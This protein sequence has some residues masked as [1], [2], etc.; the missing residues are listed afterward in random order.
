MD[1]VT[2]FAMPK[3]CEPKPSI[4]GSTLTRLGQ[5]SNHVKIPVGYLG[6]S[7]TAM[8]LIGGPAYSTPAGLD[9]D[10]NIARSPIQLSDA[11]RSI[12][13]TFPGIVWVQHPLF[14]ITYVLS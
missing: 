7:A 3:G 6:P 12:S 2:P 9:T 11:K 13:G 4:Q 14:I 5:D 8:P 10:V 1:L